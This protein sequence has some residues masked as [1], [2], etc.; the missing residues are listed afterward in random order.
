MR[1]LHPGL[2]S[3]APPLDLDGTTRGSLWPRHRWD[4]PGGHALELDCGDMGLG[5]MH[6]RVDRDVVLTFSKP[7]R[8]QPCVLGPPIGIGGHEVR[9][10]ADSHNWGDLVGVDV[11]ADGVSLINGAPISSLES[12]RAA[13]EAA[14]ATHLSRTD[15]A[16]IAGQFVTMATGIG[17]TIGIGSMFRYS[18]GHAATEVGAWSCLYAALVVGMS[19][20][21]R[22]QSRRLRQAGP[23]RRVRAAAVASLAFIGMIVVPWLIV[24]GPLH[25]H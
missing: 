18:S 23:R 14:S 4:L 17:L 9:I 22:R 6:A 19:V 12:R 11:F 10:Y 13:T 20:V 21:L 1:K 24:L 5:P 2:L 3:E 25:P 8:E 16:R 15:A 7:T